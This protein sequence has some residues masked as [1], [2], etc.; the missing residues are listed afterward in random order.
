MKRSFLPVVIC[1]A[2]SLIPAAAQN[3]HDIIGTPKSSEYE[4]PERRS[5]VC[6]SVMGILK[7]QHWYQGPT[8]GSML[9][10][11]PRFQPFFRWLFSGACSG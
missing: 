7:G 9:M 4:Q 3:K 10:G 8:G 2:T 1:L 6:G 5:A 11:C